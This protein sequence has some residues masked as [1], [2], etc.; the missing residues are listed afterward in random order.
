MFIAHVDL[1]IQPNKEAEFLKAIQ[2][3]AAQARQAAGCL[4]FRVYQE[5]EEKNRYGLYEEW[6]STAEAEAYLQSKALD[7]FREAVGPLL[8]APPHSSYYRA[9]EHQKDG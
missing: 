5:A 6:Q 7:E 1:T 2:S 4:Q 3:F 8:A 9:E